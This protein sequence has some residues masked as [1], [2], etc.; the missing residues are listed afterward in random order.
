[1]KIDINITECPYCGH[2]EYYIKQYHSGY[3]NYYFRYD[4]EEAE[5]G[6]MHNYLSSRNTSKY[7]WCGNCD[8][9][10]F[11]LEGEEL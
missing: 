10:L 5:N 8:K 3:G 6:D 7:A 4:G 11:K 2:D 1:M 9:R